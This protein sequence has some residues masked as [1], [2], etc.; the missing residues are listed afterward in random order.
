MKTTSH[1]RSPRLAGG[2]H[3][4]DDETLSSEEPVSQRTQA[5]PSWNETGFD[6]YAS[7]FPDETPHNDES[8]NDVRRVTRS[9]S[10]SRSGGRHTTAPANARV[11]G[12]SASHNSDAVR[13][14]LRDYKFSL[15]YHIH[16]LTHTS[17]PFM[18]RSSRTLGRRTLHSADP[19][20]IAEWPL[21]KT[22]RLITT[23]LVRLVH[24]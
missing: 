15:Y 9:T 14:V 10:S 21:I 11:I 19:S 2:L 7:S 18:I 12:A 17:L 4:N 8:A 20:T 16:A 5:S 24:S 23:A 6:P 1:R 22:Y 13:P 3:A